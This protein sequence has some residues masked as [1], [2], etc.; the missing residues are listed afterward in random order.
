MVKFLMLLLYLRELKSMQ[1]TAGSIKAFTGKLDYG[2]DRTSLV[3]SA[4]NC[5]SDQYP[6]ELN[7]YQSSVLIPA[8]HSGG[9]AENGDGQVP[10]KRSF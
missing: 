10:G 9:Q 3:I 6:F 7:S 4:A 1:D 8:K 5:F 2:P